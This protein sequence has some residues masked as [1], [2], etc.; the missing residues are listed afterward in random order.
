M[1]VV[2]VL[3]GACSAGTSEDDGIE[4]ATESVPDNPVSVTLESTSPPTSVE[5]EQ[6]LSASAAALADVLTRTGVDITSD[7]GIGASP[8]AVPSWQIEPLALEAISRG[9]I[10]GSVID[11]MAPMPDE[12]PSMSFL[13]A[14]W[15]TSADSPGARWSAEVLG[16]EDW[17]AAP[18][19]T[20]PIVVI[21]LFLADVLMP[22]P[23]AVEATTEDAAGLRG[24]ASV[25][26]FRQRVS[27]GPL[28]QP[29]P[30]VGLWVDVQLELI[31]QSAAL[32]ALSGAIPAPVGAYFNVAGK[33]VLADLGLLKLLLETEWA[34]QKVL[35]GQA[36]A[37]LGTFALFA[38]GLAGWTATLT[39]S[40]SS[41]RFAVGDE[42]DR[43]QT[44]TAAL[45]A[46]FPQWAPD[47]AECAAAQ[48]IDLPDPSGA[49]SSAAWHVTGLPALGTETGRDAKFGSSGTAE[50]RWNTGRENTDDGDPII[51]TV[52]ATVL[53]DSD[54]RLKML[55]M[56][57]AAYEASLSQAVSLAIAVLPQLNELAD[58]FGDMVEAAV[59][60][61]ASAT[62]AV[63]YH[64]EPCETAT[65][66]SDGRWTGPLTIDVTGDPFFSAG[67][68]QTV[69]TGQMTVDVAG[70]VVTGDWSL[71]VTASGTV[72]TEESISILEQFLMQAS[73][74]VTGT[75]AVPVIEGT[76]EYNG[77]MYVAL[78]AEDIEVD[79][80]F[81]DTVS[82]TE[83]LTL[84]HVD[85]RSATGTF[86]PS[87]NATAQGFVG[88]SGLAVWTA[89]KD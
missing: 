1:S 16:D 10:L 35:I 28:Q 34:V 88:F 12:L 73:G 86:I 89:I 70:P 3:V 5:K 82:A 6:P 4:S 14:G 38:S 48:G 51:G 8:F 45:T 7:V 78:L 29:C 40:T 21:N 20:F 55:E 39:A 77:L 84:T 43:P 79:V 58:T 62:V 18:E 27:A 61:N 57:S 15:V 54:A 44:F 17:S 9:G 56:W 32:F 83:T 42:P 50:L 74:P 30:L 46:P 53:A 52:E 19:V 22:S 80:P 37:V 71:S 69:G 87:F 76:F 2:F 11:D 24:P 66:L 31:F 47:I 85:C 41:D 72:E 75:P 63:T 59:P 68:I 67:T 64:D 26:G 36:F 81:G 60:P 65:S 33:L 49:G 13:L 23:D 25:A